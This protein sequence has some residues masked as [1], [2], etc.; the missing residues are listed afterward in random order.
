MK[1]VDYLRRR[2]ERELRCAQERANFHG[3]SV[4][5]QEY[6]LADV[7]VDLLAECVMQGARLL[8]S[9]EAG[10]LECVNLHALVMSD[11]QFCVLGQTMGWGNGLDLLRERNGGH[12]CYNDG[13]VWRHGF[14]TPDST[15]VGNGKGWSYHD[16]SI[17]W[18][19][20]IGNLYEMEG[21]A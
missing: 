7:D 17:A 1:L 11:T 4:E 13:L 18:E 10:I 12:A 15:W 9:T 2:Q 16:L 5:D 8:T 20:V 21:I 3:T 19:Y 6:D 14:D